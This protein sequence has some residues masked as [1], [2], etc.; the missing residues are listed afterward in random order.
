M[1]VNENIYFEGNVSQYLWSSEDS[2]CGD[3]N[4]GIQIQDFSL[5]FR[6]VPF[7]V[8]PIRKS[9]AMLQRRKR[10]TWHHIGIKSLKRHLLWFNLFRLRLNPARECGIS[11]I[12][13]TLRIENGGKGNWWERCRSLLYQKEK[14]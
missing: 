2:E 4:H 11:E 3:F 9:F 8:S 1:K 6:V 10:A 7:Q 12:W 13:L 14:D 5:S